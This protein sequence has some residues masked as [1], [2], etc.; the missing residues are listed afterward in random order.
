M[1]EIFRRGDRIFPETQVS[2]RTSSTSSE[3][4][5]FQHI[6]IMPP[7]VKDAVKQLKTLGKGKVRAVIK[8]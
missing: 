5:V 3:S 4:K 6:Q 1:R 7:V 8:S 2:R